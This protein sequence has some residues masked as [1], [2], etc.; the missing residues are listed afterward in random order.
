MVSKRSNP[1]ANSTAKRAPSR[2]SVSGEPRS[3]PTAEDLA[4][5]KVKGKE[6]FTRPMNEIAAREKERKEKEEAAKKARIEAAERGRIASREWAEKQKA[7][8][9]VETAAKQAATA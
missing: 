5:Q 7:K 2:S 6:A 1:L 3:A 4:N 9:A 8:K